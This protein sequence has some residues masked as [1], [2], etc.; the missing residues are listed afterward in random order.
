MPRRKPRSPIKLK[1]RASPKGS[2]LLFVLAVANELAV[3]LLHVS[4]EVKNLVRVTDLI[5]IP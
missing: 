2:S 5:V 3:N 1:K 4:D